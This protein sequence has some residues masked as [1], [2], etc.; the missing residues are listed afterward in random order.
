VV[1]RETTYD[2]A[3]PAYRLNFS[4]ANAICFIVSSRQ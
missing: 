3:P 4:I 1:A 2:S